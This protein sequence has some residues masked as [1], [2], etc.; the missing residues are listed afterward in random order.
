VVRYTTPAARS[1]GFPVVRARGCAP[2]PQLELAGRPPEAEPDAAF[3]SYV[4][5]TET[6]ERAIARRTGR[7]GAPELA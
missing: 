7:A 6:M 2:C 1:R 3:A 5:F 4:G